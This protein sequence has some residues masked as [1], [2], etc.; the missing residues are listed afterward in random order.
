MVQKKQLI[1]SSAYHLLLSSGRKTRSRDIVDFRDIET[2]TINRMKKL[3]L[4]VLIIPLFGIA[5]RLS[6]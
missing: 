6:S 3:Y 2:S 4:I 5:K 1:K